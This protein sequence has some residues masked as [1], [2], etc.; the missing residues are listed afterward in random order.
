MMKNTIKSL[1][2]KIKTSIINL[3]KSRMISG[4]PVG[5]AAGFKFMPLAMNC[6]II[7]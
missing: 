5:L 1:H 2:F 3:Y 7:W 4:D 6:Y